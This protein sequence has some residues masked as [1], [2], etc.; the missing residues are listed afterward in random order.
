MISSIRTFTVDG[1]TYAM[2]F[3]YHTILNSALGDEF[4]VFSPFALEFCLFRS[5]LED[6]ISKRIS[7]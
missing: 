7:F 6:N 5:F 4:H 3:P 2:I 1:R